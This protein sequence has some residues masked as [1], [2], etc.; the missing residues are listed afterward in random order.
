M[1]NKI[2]KIIVFIIACIV[3]YFVVYNYTS[4]IN[5]KNKNNTYESTSE[6]VNY[7]EDYINK[8]IATLLN[9]NFSEGYEMLSDNSKSL[10]KNDLSRYSEQI[11]N[12]TKIINRAPG[13]LTINLV[14]EFNMKKYIKLE[15]ELVSKSY[16]YIQN[17]ETYYADQFS[18]F[19]KFSLIEYSPNVYKIDI[20]LY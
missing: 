7:R 1:K 9:G 18:I 12:T 15:Y 4:Q 20:Q 6:S 17:N 5:S 14:N 13:G 10:F 2:I 11:F 19:K 3:I 8:Y 16:E